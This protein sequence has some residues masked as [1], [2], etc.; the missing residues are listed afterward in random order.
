MDISWESSEQVGLN[1]EKAFQHKILE[2]N[3][4]DGL[5]IEYEKM[6][7]DLGLSKKTKQVDVLRKAI[8][9]LQKLEE[10]Y[11]EV[12]HL[13]RMNPSTHT[14]LSLLEEIRQL[15][16]E[17][18]KLEGALNIDTAPVMVISHKHDPLITE[19]VQLTELAN[20][21]PEEIRLQG[22][23]QHQPAQLNFI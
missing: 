2:K 12:E 9:E 22:G 21:S 15:N 18:D 20:Y 10:S 8:S 4:R 23:F 14:L 1:V 7:Y 5:R 17:I 16:K 13:N 3:R 19:S 11:L 6:K